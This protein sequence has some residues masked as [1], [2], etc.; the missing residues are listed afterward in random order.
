MMVDLLGMPAHVAL[1]AGS[2]IGTRLTRYLR[3]DQLLII[4]AV[5]A[6]LVTVRLTVN[7]FSTPAN[8]LSP[9]AAHAGLRRGA[10]PGLAPDFYGGRIDA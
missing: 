5:L 9:A 10:V 3:A 8:L 6:L 7:I 4:L 2:T 1:A